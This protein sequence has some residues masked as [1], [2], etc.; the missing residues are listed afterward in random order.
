MRWLT[1]KSRAGARTQ[2]IDDRFLVDTGLLWIA[3]ALLG[4]GMVMLASASLA[5]ADR[6]LGQPYYYISRQTVFVL[7]GVAAGFVASR[8]PLALAERYGIVA[9][10]AAI[11]L[12][13]IVLVPGIGKEVNGST[14]WLSFGFFN[15]QPSE[16]AKLFTVIFLAG[17]LVRRGDELREERFG[18]VKPIALLALIGALLLAEPDFGTAAVLT[19]TAM[20]MLFLAGARLWQFVMLLAFILGLLALLAISSPYRMA[21]IT[22]YLDPWAD[23]FASGF[24]LTQALIAFGRGEWLGVGLGSS[25]QKLFYLPEAH[26]DFLM[27]VLGEELGLIGTLA[28][29]VLFAL[30]V[31]RAFAIG[32]RA[33]HANKPF[34]AYLAYGLGLWLGLQAFVNIG[35]N[36][37]LL[38]TKGLTLPLM[39][40]GGSSLIVS[41]IAVGLL[42][43]INHETRMALVRRIGKESPW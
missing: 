12:L 10:L 16:F 25:I 11:G 5:V 6:S 41:C 20:G 27:S 19:A 28:V 26:T 29:I 40:Y 1:A 21:R 9:L 7:L 14:R 24:Q 2:M 17:Y 3:L 22:A 30:L 31:V 39:S 23:P 8:L 18:F 33:E 15:L 38:P 34:G 37:G 13:I 35:V 43:R 32:R 4:I 42:L 36:M